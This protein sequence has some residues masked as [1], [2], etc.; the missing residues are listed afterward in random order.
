MDIDFTSALSEV[1]QEAASA[2]KDFF[3]NL[4]RS[5][6]MKESG[7]YLDNPEEAAQMEAEI[8]ATGV[9]F[10]ID[11]S[12]IS[13]K[14]VTSESLYDKVSTEGKEESYSGGQGGSVTLPD[15]TVVDSEVPQQLWGQPVPNSA[16]PPS[17]WKENAITMI[18][19]L[20][21]D[22]LRDYVKSH[23]GGKIAPVIGQH[24]SSALSGGVA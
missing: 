18:K 14:I 20:L 7:E 5:E 4:V 15:G 16:E 17:V 3:S 2:L 21:P 12:S 13:V 22:Q 9:D 8:N 6:R 1:L 23:L 10:Y 24:L 19:S 11:G